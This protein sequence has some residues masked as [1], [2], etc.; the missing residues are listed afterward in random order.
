VTIVAGVDLAWSGRKPTGICVLEARPGAVA[1]LELGCTEADADAGE[2]ASLLGRLGPDVVVGIDAPLVAGP[3]RRAEADL[4]RVFGKQGVF[5]YS[6]RR[7]FLER[8]RIAEGPRFGALLGGAGWNLDPLAL[9]PGSDGRHA[10]EVFP[11]ASIVSLLGAPRAL[12]YKKGAIAARL[13]PL[14][15][16]RELLRA[17]LGVELS[18]LQ[19][20]I[21]ET[22]LFGMRGRELKALEDKLDALACAVSALHLWRHGPGN[23]H[24]FG[25]VTEG[26]IVVPRPVTSSPAPSCP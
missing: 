13:R 5:A 21:L 7:D 26:Y 16:F 10:L 19:C 1:L 9:A 18:G 20:D 2:V 6:A 8:H 25:D 3:N 17:H 22:P 24:I 4:A 15:E 14:A 23:S 12:K 11:H